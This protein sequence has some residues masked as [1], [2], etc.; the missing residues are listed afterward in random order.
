[1]ATDTEAAIMDA[2]GAYPRYNPQMA[3]SIVVQHL[4]G[5]LGIRHP[6]SDDPIVLRND[7]DHDSYKVLWTDTGGHHHGRMWSYRKHYLDKIT[8]EGE[9]YPTICASTEAGTVWAYL[10]VDG[11][12]WAEIQTARGR[13]PR[14]DVEQLT[15]DD[16]RSQ[17]GLSLP[18]IWQGALW[19]NEC[20]DGTSFFFWFGDDGAGD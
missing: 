18:M 15:G 13:N 9:L 11:T 5:V 7:P 3:E 4:R 2:T 8:L 12:E 10:D 19:T 17:L 14:I 6:E 20:D 16:E 1:V